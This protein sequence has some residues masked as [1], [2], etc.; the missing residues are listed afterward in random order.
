MFDHG[1]VCPRFGHV[2]KIII[3]ILIIDV[4]DGQFTADE[5]LFQDLGHRFGMKAYGVDGMIDFQS[6]N[7]PEMQIRRQF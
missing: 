3:T 4:I 7:L 1:T 6:R 5:E 2:V